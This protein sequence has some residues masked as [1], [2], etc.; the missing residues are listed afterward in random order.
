MPIV[1]LA[2]TLTNVLYVGTMNSLDIYHGGKL[3]NRIPT[4][5]ITKIIINTT[6]DKLYTTENNYNDKVLI[7]IWD[8][9]VEQDPIVIFSFQPDYEYV[10]NIDFYQSTELIVIMFGNYN[11]PIKDI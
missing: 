7:K 1:T 5:R 9:T 11:P 3:I 4:L 6:G 2:T 8:I 10:Q